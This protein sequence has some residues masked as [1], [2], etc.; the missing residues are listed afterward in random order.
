[1]TTLIL[2]ALNLLIYYKDHFRTFKMK[3]NGKHLLNSDGMNNA[4]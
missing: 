4:A 2:K 3:W 1:M